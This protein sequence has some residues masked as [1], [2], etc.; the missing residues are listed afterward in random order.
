MGTCSGQELLQLLGIPRTERR[1]RPTALRG[2]GIFGD[3]VLDQPP[4]PGIAERLAQHDMH[5]Q[6]RLGF[7]PSS[8]VE[9]PVD[10]QLG[11]QRFQLVGTE[12]RSNTAPSFGTTW[13]SSRRR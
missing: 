6:D 10:D 4:S 11:I 9:P 8:A 12:R 5:F 13:S 1:T 7:E 3:V 2:F